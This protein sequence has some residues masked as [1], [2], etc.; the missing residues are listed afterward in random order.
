MALLVGVSAGV[1][2]MPVQ[3]AWAQGAE[4]SSRKRVAV[5]ELKGAKTQSAREFLIQGFED[6]Y[7]V[8]VVAK[9][10]APVKQGASASE[11]AAA[12]A[13]VGADAIV[14]GTSTL[15]PKKGWVAEIA[16]YNGED[17]SLIEEFTVSGGSWENYRAALSNA[18]QF[19]GAIDKARLAPEPEPEPEPEE[20]DLEEEPQAE[21][22]TGEAR[23]A[24]DQRRPPL[25]ARLGARLYSRSFRYTDTMND[26]FPNQGYPDL[27][28]YN[29]AA[30]PM[31]FAHIDWYPLAHGQG[32]FPA[33]IGLTAGYEL[34][35]ATQ[36]Q[37]RSELL[38]QSHSMW[39]VGP[40]VRLPIDLHEVGVFGTFGSHSF[41]ITGD[42]TTDEGRPVFP[43]VNYKFVDLGVDAR[44]FVENVRLGAF[45]KYRKVLGYGDLSSGEW[46][47]NTT[48]DAVS[49]GG[50]VGWKLSSVLDLLVGVDVLQYGLSFKPSLDAA[51]NRIAG[52]ATDRYV[53][54][55]G[56]IGFTWPT[57]SDSVSVS[58]SS[59]GGGGGGDDDDFDD[60][61]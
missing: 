21:Q 9:G 50:E 40:K 18:T 15:K 7:S 53:S 43:D 36:V 30:A 13:E 60:F 5:G 46:F 42:E 51:D 6:E 57:D 47:P 24:T 1:A 35:V 32:G 28:T 49:I 10:S 54:V 37:F 26:L 2:V 44:F 48:G 29:L 45:A 11:I 52:G 23:D 41:K 61:D 19:M 8:E 31:V 34:G 14:L 58:A 59:S 25:Y 33:N 56:A 22:A 16:V 39:F 17:G 3:D 38:Q 55:W 27:L 4:Q 20:E 12:A